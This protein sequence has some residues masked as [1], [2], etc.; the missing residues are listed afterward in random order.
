MGTNH[1]SGQKKSDTD[2]VDA[3]IEM[4]TEMNV[5]MEVKLGKVSLKND[6]CVTEIASYTNTQCCIRLLSLLCL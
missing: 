6:N 5:A 1:T 4:N 3:V 2:N